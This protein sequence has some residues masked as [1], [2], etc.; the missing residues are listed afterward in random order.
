MQWTSAPNIAGAPLPQRARGY[1]K[2]RF[3]V[4][5]ERLEA[6]LERERGQLPPWFAVGF[7]G[8]I[9]AWFTLDQPRQWVAFLCIAAGLALAGFLARGSRAERA[10]CTPRWLK[11]DRRTLERTGGVAL[12]LGTRPRI[13]TVVGRIGA[14]PWKADDRFGMRYRRRSTVAERQDAPI[15]DRT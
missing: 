6:F 12:Y 5:R 11:L 7:G 14:H 9:A 1:W 3:G 15:R 8:G 10:R 2:A 13:D 4:A